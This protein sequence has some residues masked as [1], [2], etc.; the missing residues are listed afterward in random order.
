M[1]KSTIFLLTG[2]LIFN[3]VSSNEPT[4]N[5]YSSQL[6]SAV[7]VEDVEILTP[8]NSKI[9]NA[10]PP[11]IYSN[12]WISR[13]CDDEGPCFDLSYVAEEDGEH[14]L[15][16][17]DVGDTFA[18]VFNP[19]AACIVQE[20]Y[21]QWY[22][23]QPGE[24]VIAFGADYGNVVEISPNGDSYSIPRGSTNLSPIGEIRTAP[25]LNSV[26]GSN[27]NW[28]DVS[29]LDIGG[30]FPVG[31]ESNITSPPSFVIAYIK[32]SDYSIPYS[33]DN[34]YI[35]REENYTWIGGSLNIDEP[36]V[37]GQ[38]LNYTELMMLVKVSYPWGR[39]IWTNTELLSSTFISEGTR[40]IKVDVSDDVDE[41]TG[42]AITENDDIH[43]LISI[44]GIEYSDLPF[45][46]AYEVDVGETG[47]GFYAWDMTYSAN[48]GDSISYQIYS[49]DDDGLALESDIKSFQIKAPNNINADLLIINDGGEEQQVGYELAADFYSIP[50]EL[51][52][53]EEN[54]G[55]DWSIINHGWSNILIY[56]SGSTSL[57]VIASETDP[58]Y[59]DFLNNGG[60]LMLIDQD[61]FLGHDLD[62]YPEELSFG[63]GDPAYDWFGVS[64]GVNDPNE[65]INDSD[66]EADIHL[67]SML[68]D[69]TDLNLNHS[70]YST[71]NWGDF[72][73]PGMAD[74]VYQ[75]EFTGEVHGIRYDNGISKTALFTF[76]A[77]AAIGQIDGEYYYLPEFYQFV[78]YFLVWFDTG[79]PPDIRN[80][81]GPSGITIGAN[82]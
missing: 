36:G 41:T 47:N 76:M 33:N 78:N 18:V 55:I 2:L 50:N 4:R 26:I 61:W 62:P 68:E 69:L 52:T 53:I 67:E 73:T 82:P 12:R 80:V 75:G 17:G 5:R 63:P 34:R 22:H 40:T 77:D 9:R 37:W 66:G 10:I 11:Y 27:P 71:S 45:D 38:Y 65:N 46:L 70:L 58:G 20:V 57:P 1:N 21:L 44:N 30:T 39:P 15:S 29:L 23:T 59:G 6:P 28:S 64:G 35:G 8:I 14:F 32:N 49:I 81:S 24:S 54:N 74:A 7:S 51:W 60:N 79:R 13:G 42:F 43:L 16:S 25:T 56:G 3:V 31:D 19:P 48:V 72:I